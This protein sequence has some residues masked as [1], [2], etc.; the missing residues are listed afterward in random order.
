MEDFEPLSFEEVF[1]L[2][3]VK[4]PSDLHIICPICL[5]DISSHELV[6]SL[7]CDMKHSC[8]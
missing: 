8:H 3:A 6:A 7:G 1:A 4:V 5:V 2:L